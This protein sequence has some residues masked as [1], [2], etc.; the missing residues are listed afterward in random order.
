MRILTTTLL[1]AALAFA[2]PAYADHGHKRYGHGYQHG[3]YKHQRHF[4]GHRDHR[5]GPPRWVAQREVN[6]HYYYGNSAPSASIPPGVHVI[7]PDI[8]FPWQ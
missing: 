2:V 6:N 8:F 1:A 5:H 4:H 7:F 3:H